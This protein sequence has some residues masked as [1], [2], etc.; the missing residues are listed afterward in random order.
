MPIPKNKKPNSSGLP[1]LSKAMAKPKMPKLPPKQEPELPQDD[2]DFNQDLTPDENYNGGQ[3]SQPYTQEQNNQYSQPPVQNQP[4]Q[5]YNQQLNNQPNNYNQPQQSQ[6]PDYYNNPAPQQ[7]DYYNQQ[8]TAQSQNNNYQQPN[9]NNDY[10]QSQYNQQPSQQGGYNQPQQ[11]NNNYSQPQ[12]PQPSYQP[13]P[14]QQQQSYQEES[15]QNNSQ[16]E[17]FVQLS[18]KQVADEDAADE[19][20][21]DTT[22]Q[23]T[24]E[25]EEDYYDTPPKKTVGK[26]K[27][28]MRKKKRGEVDDPFYGDSDT[29][30]EDPDKYID[31]KRK[32]IIPTGGKKSRPRGEKTKK[33]QGTSRFDGRKNAANTIKMARIAVIIGLVGLFGFGIKN[34]FFQQIPN[35][36][37]IAAIARQT[38]GDTGYPVER[39]QALAEQF[40]QAYLTYDSTNDNDRTLSYFYNGTEK[41][42]TIPSVTTRVFDG[43]VKQSTLVDPKTF[44]VIAGNSYSYTFYVSTLVT[45]LQNGQTNKAG[46]QSSRWVALAINV[47][48]DK[49]HN[50]MSISQDSP[51]LVPSFKVSKG[52]VYSD[53]PGEKLGTGDADDVAFK[54]M[55]PTITGYLT[56]YA[57]SNSVKHSKLNQYIETKPD[58]SVIDGF[59]GKFDFVNDESSFSGQAY[60]V[61]SGDNNN[62]WKVD[63]KV[64]WKDAQSEKQKGIT[65][66]GHYV[67]TIKKRDSKYFVEKFVPYTYVKPS[68]D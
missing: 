4:Q 13:Q 26:A 25:E 50:E 8:G 68:G 63:L 55:T 62:E 22:N 36:N 5:D 9:G 48:Y 64:G 47:L 51:S 49:K 35:A 46:E 60:P 54:A 57:A 27:K 24:A 65:Y 30:N 67:M 40:A 44:D 42:T 41:T 10:G 14:A 7:P 56:A 12:Q 38:N 33:F 45:D 61:S 29:Q 37:E 19:V 17:G 2:V 18:E 1:D 66:T 59:S 6:Q 28:R 43:S 16:E 21:Q 11:Q 34:T 58:S 32:K 53:T 31:K 3:S 23:Y 52:D 15:Q 20:E 39:G